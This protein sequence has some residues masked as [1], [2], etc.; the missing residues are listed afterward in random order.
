MFERNLAAIFFSLLVCGGSV[1]GQAPLGVQYS[2]VQNLRAVL[3]EAVAP[4]PPGDSPSFNNVSDCDSLANQLRLAE[5]M[6]ASVNKEINRLARVLAKLRAERRD[7]NAMFDPL[8]ISKEIA[9]FHILLTRELRRRIILEFAI[10][11]LEAELWQCLNDAF[12][13]VLEELIN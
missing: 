1:F 13:D 5:A 9:H 6:L 2:D 8:Y 3:E 4:D 12:E 11:E 10:L 7:P